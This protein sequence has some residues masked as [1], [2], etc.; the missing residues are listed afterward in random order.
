MRLEKKVIFAIIFKKENIMI[1]SD[2]ISIMGSIITFLST[3]VTILYANKAKKYK[4]QTQLNI[5]KINLTD[6][7]EKLKRIQNEVREL[8]LKFPIKRGLKPENT[9]KTIKV[10]FDFVLNLIDS[11]SLDAKIRD[12]ISEA[13]KS[14]NQYEAS[15]NKD[16][17]KSDKIINMTDLLQKAISKSNTI[18][19]DL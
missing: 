4:E 19:K 16:K 10:D 6:V 12:F 17:I 7:V 8:P 15:L 13:Q 11:D 18:V 14:L 5:R 2:F 1:S 9:I 3:I